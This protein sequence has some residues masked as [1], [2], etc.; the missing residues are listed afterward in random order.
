MSYSIRYFPFVRHIQERGEFTEKLF[1]TGVRAGCR[2]YK[3]KTHFQLFNIFP[4]RKENF[5]ILTDVVYRRKF[6][7]IRLHC[8]FNFEVLTQWQSFISSKN[9]NDT[10]EE[11]QPNVGAKTVMQ[12]NYFQ[13]VIHEIIV[14]KFQLN[15]LNGSFHQILL[16]WLPFMCAGA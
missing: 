8:Y 5:S 13:V 2:N 16:L 4:R 11:S 9:N 1:V 3:R 12:T 6:E 14:N 10:A 7:E 15:Y